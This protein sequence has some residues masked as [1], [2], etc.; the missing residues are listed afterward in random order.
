MEITHKYPSTLIVSFLGLLVTMIFG[1]WWVISFVTAYIKYHPNS[2]EP[3]PA[4]DLP[5]GH[6]SAA[7]L[8]LVLIFFGTLPVLLF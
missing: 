6:C 4:C 1:A 7:G 3:N 8:V 2:Y 5:G